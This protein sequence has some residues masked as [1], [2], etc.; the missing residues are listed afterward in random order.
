MRLQCFDCWYTVHVL[1]V[2]FC[3][4]F[5]WHISPFHTT[6]HD[7][8]MTSCLF[9]AWQVSER[10]IER[11]ETKR[12]G[13]IDVQTPVQ[14]GK[15]VPN[16]ETPLVG[17]DKLKRGLQISASDTRFPRRGLA[18][19]A[20]RGRAPAQR[21]CMKCILTLDF[22]VIFTELWSRQSP[23][24]ANLTFEA[25][26]RKRAVLSSLGS[27]FLFVHWEITQNSEVNTADNIRRVKQSRPISCQSYS[28]AHVHAHTHTRVHM[29]APTTSTRTYTYKFYLG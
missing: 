11:P 6:L 4:S 3:T 14:P 2:T 17:E 16:M 7:F 5:V 13:A 27:L 22:V 29:T 21:V 20:T 1:S 24:P 8:Y 12:R 25:K 9:S 18:R 19:P 10:T 15:G 23:T 26:V 28:H